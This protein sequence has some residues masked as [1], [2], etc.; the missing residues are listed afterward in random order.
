METLATRD[1][2]SFFSLL[3]KKVLSQVKLSE[4][5]ESVFY[6][7][8]RDTIS[9]H[10]NDYD[11]ILTDY[12]NKGYSMGA[13]YTLLLLQS[14]PREDFQAKRIITNEVN[15]LWKP[16]PRVEAYLKDYVFTA[17][18]HVKERITGEVNDI[19]MQGYREGKGIRE[20]G[21][22][23]EKNFN[24]LRD[25]E[26]LRIATTELN[27]ARNMASFETLSNEGLSYKIWNSHH[28]KRTRREHA[29]ID[30][31]I[32]PV[33]ERFSNGLMYPG[34]KVGPPREWVNCRCSVAAFIIP[35]GRTAPPF[36][37]F[38]EKDLIKI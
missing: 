4:P 17:S 30:G 23:I 7:Y 11:K 13:A 10:W 22:R 16:N 21:K 2:S 9:K 26:S 29:L 15:D 35:P 19:L 3:E 36:H 8:V 31:E 20:T 37:P 14:L 12:I 6:G 25:Y 34:E 18:Q 38:K 27:S 32:V 24:N 33:N 1:I 5:L 28:D